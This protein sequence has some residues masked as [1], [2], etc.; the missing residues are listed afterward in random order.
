MN[1]WVGVGLGGWAGVSDDT[2]VVL[3]AP[4]SRLHPCCIANVHRH[5]CSLHAATGTYLGMASSTG[6]ARPGELQSPL[7]LDL[8]FLAAAA[9]AYAGAAYRSSGSASATRLLLNECCPSSTCSL[10]LSKTHRVAFLVIDMWD[11]GFGLVPLASTHTFATIF[12]NLVCII[13][14]RCGYWSGK[15]RNF[16]HESD[17][18][19][20]LTKLCQATRSKTAIVANSK[21]KR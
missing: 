11:I 8:D 17:R 13:M 12:S 7:S 5:T 4:H 19:T 9:A 15:G 1:G 6:A 10:L 20:P 16:Q 14:R 2:H 21:L 18:T 3:G